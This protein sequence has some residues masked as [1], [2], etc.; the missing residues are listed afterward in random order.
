MEISESTMTK[1]I[2][3][4]LISG[5]SSL[6]PILAAV[7][8]ES[9]RVGGRTSEYAY[10]TVTNYDR[11]ILYRF[12]EYS[13]YVEYYTLD[14]V[15]YSDFNDSGKGQY[16][17]EFSFLTEKGTKELYLTFSDEV[18]GGGFPHQRP[19]AI[20]LFELLKSKMI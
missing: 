17:I 6:C 7:K 15:M 2:M 19:N 11:I 8:C 16:I 5:E 4:L 10:V 3:P 20:Y 18:R 12:N 13:S 1:S 14:T 9:K